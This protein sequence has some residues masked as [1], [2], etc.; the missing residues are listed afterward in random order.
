MSL[1]VGAVVDYSPPLSVQQQCV[2][3]VRKNQ[4]P[5][6]LISNLPHTGL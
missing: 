5:S 1:T 2:A 3:T 4:P 6:L